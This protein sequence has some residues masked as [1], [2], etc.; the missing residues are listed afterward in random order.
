MKKKIIN[1]IDDTLMKYA[2]EGDKQS[3]EDALREDI[4]DFKAYEKK[5]GDFAKRIEFM[6]KASERKTNDIRLLEMATSLF[7][8]AIE[9]NIDKPLATLKTILQSQKKFAFSNLEHLSKEDIV[10]IIKDQ[11]LVEL[12]ENLEKGENEN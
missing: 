7:K 3:I 1:R 5:R 10:E 6:A 2:M 12:L 8:N 9:K 11:N 4:Q